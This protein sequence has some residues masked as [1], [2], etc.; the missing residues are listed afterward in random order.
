MIN[1]FN[2]LFIRY[3]LA[4]MPMIAIGILNGVLREVAYGKHLSE[5]RAHQ[6]STL[7]GVAL[8]G[9]YIWGVTQQWPLESAEQAIAI[10]FAWL[11]LTVIFE[12]SFGHF[13]AK[14]PWSRLLHDYNLLAGRIWLVVLIWIAAAPYVFSRF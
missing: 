1:L 9:I 14:L 11:V 3:L 6:T 13:V 5:L 7:T 4:W 12:F 10:G 8:F 2:P